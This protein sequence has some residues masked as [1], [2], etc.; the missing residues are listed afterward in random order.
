M[1]KYTEEFKRSIVDQYL[2]GQNGFQSLAKSHGL[3]KEMVRRWV[4]NFRLYG[5]DG[6]R[7]KFSH[8]SA[9]F[10]LSVLKYM[11]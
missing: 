10:R 7:K 8:Y 2:E 3:D 5:A 1:T 4:E 9:Q 11:W 6:L